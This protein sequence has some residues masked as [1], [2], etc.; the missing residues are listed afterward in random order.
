MT[1][2]ITKKLADIARISGDGYHFISLRF[3]LEALES[4]P[5]QTEASIM[6]LDMINK[7]HKLCLM[8]EQGRLK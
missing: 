1:Q 8:A 3:F 7:F 5:E 4:S 2:E 6:A